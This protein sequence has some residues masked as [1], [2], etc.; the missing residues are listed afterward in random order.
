EEWSLVLD[1]S[2][3]WQSP[4]MRRLALK[5]LDEN[6]IEPS[7]RLRLAVD[8]DVEDW[9]RVAYKGICRRRCFPT[10]QDLSLIPSSRIVNVFRIRETL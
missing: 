9:L 10:S 6:Y 3:R 2:Y 5:R 1:T 4:W 7:V 8:Y